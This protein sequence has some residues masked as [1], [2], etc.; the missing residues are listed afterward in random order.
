[1]V[2]NYV[3]SASAAEEVARKARDL[4]VRATVIKADVS[5]TGEVIAL[6]EK[7]KAELGRID[8]VMSNSGIEHFG[9]LESVT[10]AQFDRVYAVNVRPQFI[11]A[12]QAHKH[13]E[14]GGRLFLIGSVSANFVSIYR[15]TSCSKHLQTIISQ[16]EKGLTWLAH[17]G[18]RATRYTPRPKQRYRE[19]PSLWRGTLPINVSR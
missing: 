13:I 10:E 3:S 17:R 16:R 18:S 5:K 6:F 2:I 4:G 11:V 7:A 1:V 8:I 14:E 9:D 15:L 19:W 12:Q